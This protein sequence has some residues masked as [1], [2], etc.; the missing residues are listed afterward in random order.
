MVILTLLHLFEH[1]LFHNLKG[2]T[3]KRASAKEY[4]RSRNIS[5]TYT[6]CCSSC[7]SFNKNSI[8]VITM[9]MLKTTFGLPLEDMDR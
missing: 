2:T 5:E 6:S 3:R 8:H 7:T 4:G 1:V 9:A